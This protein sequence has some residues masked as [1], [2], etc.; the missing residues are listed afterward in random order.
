MSANHSA[1]SSRAGISAN[2][3]CDTLKPYSSEASSVRAHTIAAAFD[4]ACFH[5]RFKTAVSRRTFP[6]PDHSLTISAACLDDT[7]RDT[8][9]AGC[10][11][12]ASVTT[13]PTLALDEFAAVRNLRVYVT[14]GNDP[15]GCCPDWY[16][17]KC[18]E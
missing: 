9:F 15:D 17:L 7:F 5:V 6:S 14:A 4:P 1:T 2:P 11:G 13:R 8:G 12:M 18:G 3:S 16:V 10:R